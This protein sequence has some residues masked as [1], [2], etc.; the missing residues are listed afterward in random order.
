M[1][2][3]TILPNRLKL[4][5]ICLIK[6]ILVWSIFAY[7]RGFGGGIYLTLCEEE[8]DLE[9]ELKF[10]TQDVDTNKFEEIKIQKGGSIS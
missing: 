8:C 7:I 3:L 5:S 2:L 9:N 1:N 6:K 4:Y 10:I